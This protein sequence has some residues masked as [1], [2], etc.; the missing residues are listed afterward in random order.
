MIGG[1]SGI[2]DPELEDA[3][4]IKQFSTLPG[5]DPGYDSTDMKKPTTAGQV[6][7]APMSQTMA[8]AHA[9]K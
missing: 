2:V 9:A 3:N 6:P 7:A 8:H 4:P 5:T 1:C